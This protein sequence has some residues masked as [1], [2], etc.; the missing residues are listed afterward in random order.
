MKMDLMVIVYLGLNL[1]IRLW[2]VDSTEEEVLEVPM[3]NLYVVHVT[4]LDIFLL[5]VTH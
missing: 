2:I 1:V 3:K 4:M 5:L